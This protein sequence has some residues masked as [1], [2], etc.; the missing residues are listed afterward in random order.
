MKYIWNYYGGCS[1]DDHFSVSIYFTKDCNYRCSYCYQT[2]YNK[3]ILNLKHFELIIDQFIKKAKKENREI[4]F[5][6]MGGELLYLNEN[7]QKEIFKIFKNISIK[8]DYKINIDISTNFYRSV[9]WFV[10]FFNYLENELKINY[11]IIYTISVHEEYT[12][13]EK[14]LQKINDI[15]N[16][17][18][19]NKI[20]FSFYLLEKDFEFVNKYN[21][22][23]ND[24]I[25]DIS[26][27]EIDHK[28]YE[29]FKSNVICNSFIFNVLP[30]GTIKNACSGEILENFLKINKLKLIKRI[31]PRKKC[32]CP[33]IDGLV[34]K[35]I[36][37]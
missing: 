18:K 1:F 25:V 33:A 9:E 37:K 5:T 10:R 29:N 20:K 30:D 6:L 32:V 7:Y 4:D 21:H 35:E 16:K 13:F 31:C 2:D 36:K 24:Y 23:F 3:K 28:S 17:I 14:Q 12:T 8:N 27:N 19:L 11:N 15:I 34:K 26:F 22:Y